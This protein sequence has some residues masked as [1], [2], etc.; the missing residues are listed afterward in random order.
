MFRGAYSSCS[1][2]L[3]RERWIDFSEDDAKCVRRRR[4]ICHSLN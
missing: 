4:K 1:D 2:S 3:M